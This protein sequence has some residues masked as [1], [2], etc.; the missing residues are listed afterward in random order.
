MKLRHPDERH[1][2]LAEK[3]VLVREWEDG[4]V[5]I[6]YWRCDG[7]ALCQYRNYRTVREKA[8]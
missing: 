5:I 3:A 1:R 4:R 8:I 7:R 6:T 2:P